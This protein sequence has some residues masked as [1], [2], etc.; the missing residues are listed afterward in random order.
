M[1][2]LNCFE[3][4]NSVTSDFWLPRSKRIFL[5][6]VNKSLIGIFKANYYI[7]KKKK[8]VGGNDEST[9]GAAIRNI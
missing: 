1:L 9:D 3:T 2:D 8:Q 7:M 6:E 5:K 4:L